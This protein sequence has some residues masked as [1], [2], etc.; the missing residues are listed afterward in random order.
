MKKWSEMFPDGRWVFYEGDDPDGFADEMVA[1]FGFDPRK[2]NPS[3]G[4]EH[5]ELEDEGKFTSYQFLCPGRCIDQVYGSDE[6]PL[7]S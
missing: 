3:W 7:G 4:A 6:Y 2:D 1:K 5:G